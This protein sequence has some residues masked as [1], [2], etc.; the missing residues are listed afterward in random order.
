MAPPWQ[1]DGGAMER[2]RGSATGEALQQQ[3]G[4]MLA[5]ARVK[6]SVLQDRVLLQ[7]ALLEK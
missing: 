3:S 2:N 7:D 1:G 5:E 4:S 6:V